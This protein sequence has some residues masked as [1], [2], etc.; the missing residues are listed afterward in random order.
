MKFGLIFE[1]RTLHFRY[2]I[3]VLFF[4]LITNTLQISNESSAFSRVESVGANDEAPWP[5]GNWTTSTL[6]EQGMDPSDI[7]ALKSYTNRFGKEIHSML[8]V[9]NWYLVEEEYFGVNSRKDIPHPVYSVTK[10]VTS[11]LVGIAIDEGYLS[12][13]NETVIDF[14][15]NKTFQNMDAN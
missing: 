8:I 12:G 1:K 5:T 15:P 2:G 3:L 6:L 10:S 7:T 9:R 14:F 13:V 4:L 11:T